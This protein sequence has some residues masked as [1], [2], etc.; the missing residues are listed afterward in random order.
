[1]MRGVRRAHVPCGL[2]SHHVPLCR[3][4]PAAAGSVVTVGDTTNGRAGTSWVGVE[5]PHSEN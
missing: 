2:L 3:T 4:L 1:M 5:A